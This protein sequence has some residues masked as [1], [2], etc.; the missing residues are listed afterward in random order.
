MATR[1]AALR[2]IALAAAAG[3]SLSA[4]SGQSADTGSTG[5]T[6]ADGKPKGDITFLTNRTDLDKDG[7]IANYV[8]EFKKEYPEINVK[9][10]AITNYADDV[11]TR[12]S[13]PNGY[14]DVLLIPNVPSDQFATFFEPL[15]SVSELAST[16]RFQAPASFDGTQYGIAL[17]G[18]ANGILYNTEVFTKAGITELPKTSAE[19]LAALKTI[20][21]KVPGIAPYYTNYKDGWPLGGQ[22]SAN[23]GAVT[24][25]PE[26]Q[27]KMAHNKTPWTEGTDIYAIDS[28]LFDIVSSKLSEADPLTTNWEQS[29][30]DFVQGKIATMTL[31][32]WA[33]SQFTAKATELGVSTDTVG[34]MTFPATSGGKQYATI[35]GDY[36]LAINKNSENKAAARAWLDWLVEKSGFTDDQGMISAVKS[37]E[38]PDN[39]SSL[40]DNGV[41]LIEVAA[42]AKGEEALFNNIADKSKVDIWGNVYRQKLIDVA[43][44][45]ADGDKASYFAGLNKAWGDAEASLAK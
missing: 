26:A 27:N 40:E 22:W 19:F 10:E 35:G 39:L 32:S 29:K 21:S 8:A 14:G 43:R 30:G 5:E 36:N 41:E 45:Q 12:M 6:G 38:L 1:K 13:T 15:G 28:L 23:I 25:D 9:V 11:K 33:I 2:L 4:C 3:L 42:A 7:T 18:N 37:A 20:Q 34:F 24:G 16:Y 44:G 31:G 17:G